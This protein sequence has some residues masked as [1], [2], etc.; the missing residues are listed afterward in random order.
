MNENVIQFGLTQKE[1]EQL[2]NVLG[3]LPTKANVYNVLVK[4]I[5]QYNQAVA[6]VESPEAE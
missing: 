4:I 3:E 5:N 1:V 2:V 6:P